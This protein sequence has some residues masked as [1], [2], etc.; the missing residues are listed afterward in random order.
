[1]SD[2]GLSRVPDGGV[3]RR[4]PSGIEVLRRQKHE[5]IDLSGLS[6]ERLA[7]ATD[8]RSG[9]KFSADWTIERVTDFVADHVASAGWG[10]PP[11][12]TT[13]VDLRQPEPVGYSDGIEVHTIRIVRAGRYVHAFPVG[14]D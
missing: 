6:R 5:P 7:S 1:M 13:H 10:F 11:A 3:L 14:D 9:S 2:A 4:L 8:K 12:A